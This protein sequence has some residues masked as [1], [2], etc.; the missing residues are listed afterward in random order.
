MSYSDQEQLK[1]FLGSI[2]PSFVQYAQ[3]LIDNGLSG[4]EDFQ[5]MQERDY[6]KSKKCPSFEKFGAKTKLKKKKKDGTKKKWIKKTKTATPIE[7]DSALKEGDEISELSKKKS[8]SKANL[9]NTEGVKITADANGAAK[10]KGSKVASWTEGEVGLWVKALQNGKY[11]KYATNFETMHID[12]AHLLTFTS[13]DDL[14]DIVPDSTDRS[15]IFE[16]IGHLQDG[17]VSLIQDTLDK[18]S[19]KESINESGSRTGGDV[20]ASVPRSQEVGGGKG[21]G[22]GGEMQES[23]LPW[24]PVPPSAEATGFRVSRQNLVAKPKDDSYVKQRV[25]K[26]FEIYDPSKLDDPSEVDKLISTYRGREEDLFSELE[27]KYVLNGPKASYTRKQLNRSFD[28]RTDVVLHELSRLYQQY[29]RHIEEAYSFPAFH[30]PLLDA[31]DFMA[32]PMVL[33]VGQ[34]S[35]GKTTFIRYLVGR[36][37]PGMSI[38]PEPTTDCFSA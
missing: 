5:I 36:D 8:T 3:K 6:E 1:A 4:S 35:T 14:A 29:T 15:F 13:A 38:G 23:S 26:F 18:E 33:L 20:S 34:Y 24:A 16:S 2:N 9:E 11:C 37:F 32:K 7:E 25:I 10:E 22:G 12:G 21:G 19:E 31:V 17:T 27:S 28:N 30:S